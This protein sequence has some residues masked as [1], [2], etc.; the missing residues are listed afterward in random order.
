[1]LNI[2]GTSVLTLLLIQLLGEPVHGAENIQDDKGIFLI[3]TYE[4]HKIM[5]YFEY[6]GK[7]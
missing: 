5:F 7:S 6:I 4:L 2:S 3:T 1:M